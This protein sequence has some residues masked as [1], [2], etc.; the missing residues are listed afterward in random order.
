MR[1][2]AI[3]RLGGEAVSEIQTSRRLNLGLESEFHTRE[4]GVWNEVG[5]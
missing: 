1:F 5:V 4:E 3:K 2:Q